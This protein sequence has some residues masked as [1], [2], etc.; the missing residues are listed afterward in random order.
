MA[1]SIQTVGTEAEIFNDFDLIALI[2]LMADE[3]RGHPEE[4]PTI[5]PLV[6]EWSASLA[7]YGPGL[8]E[9]RLDAIASSARAM[10]EFSVLLSSVEVRIRRCGTVPASFLN[11]RCDAPG[12]EFSDYS[13]DFLLQAVGRL[14]KLVSAPR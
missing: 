6:D 2:C 14:Q 1:H 7:A 11:T 4:F 8:I 3:V 10:D 5:A 13:G 9:L 12:I